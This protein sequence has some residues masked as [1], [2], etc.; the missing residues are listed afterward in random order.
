MK[1]QQFNYENYKLIILI[2]RRLKHLPYHPNTEDKVVNE[3]N[4]VF[5][6]I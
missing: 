1:D 4:I 6:T 2:V 3:M 5:Y